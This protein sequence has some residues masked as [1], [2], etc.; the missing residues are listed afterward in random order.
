MSHASPALTGKKSGDALPS[1]APSGQ[2]YDSSYKTKQSE[3]IPVVDDT[4][5][6]EDGVGPEMADSDEQLALGLAQD[7]MDAID[8]GNIIEDRTRGA[9]PTGSYSEGQE[10]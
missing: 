3:P 8:K 1:E 7:D 9:K 10:E 2:V 4:A 5:Q 6:V